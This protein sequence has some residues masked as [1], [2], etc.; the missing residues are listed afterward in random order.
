MFIHYLYIYVS[1]H[2][3]ISRNCAEG[4]GGAGGGGGVRW[5]G[6]G[7]LTVFLAFAW[8]ISKTMLTD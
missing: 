4:C 1:L 8:R 6:V 5:E 7:V 3:C 2:M